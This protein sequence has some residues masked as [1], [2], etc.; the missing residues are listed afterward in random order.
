MCEPIKSAD[1][2][3]LWRLFYSQVLQAGESIPE[4]FLA[5]RTWGSPD[6]PAILYPTWYS[7]DIVADNGWLIDVKHA[8]LNPDKYFIIVPAYFGNSQS[9][10]PSNSKL[11]KK[12]P[13]TS[14][15][16]NA[17]AQHE[18]ITKELKIS[19]LFAVLG[20]SMG[21]AMTFQWATAYPDFMDRA[22][23]FCGAART[24]HHNITFLRSLIMALELDP[25]FKD[26]DYTVAEQPMGGK[27]VF[28][29][30]YSIMGFSGS[31]YRQEL[32]KEL[33]YATR[34]EFL[35]GFWTPLFAHKDALNLRHML[36]TWIAADITCT[37]GQPWSHDPKNGRSSTEDYKLA[38]ASIKTSTLV[39]P[40]RTDMYF[41]P[42]DSEFEVAHIPKGSLYVMESIWGHFAG[43][44]GLNPVD[45]KDLDEVIGRHFAQ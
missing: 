29:A 6:L 31:F 20:W 11:G 8:G 9:S 12:F 36:R 2:V 4:C 26:G 16:D 7:G 28:A 24:A 1:S 37:P 5:Y 22:I 33:G 38:L 45:V 17:R 42:E 27:A 40:C 18:L 39:V 10:S 44:P 19:H 30:I 43:G 15:Y 35:D 32:F 34:D 41:P 23:P 25:K 21:A 14:V 13:H 3:T